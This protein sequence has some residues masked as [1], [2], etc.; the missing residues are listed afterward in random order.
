MFLNKHRLLAYHLLSYFHPQ[1]YVLFSSGR[2]KEQNIEQK[3]YYKS[4][5]FRFKACIR[6]SDVG[7]YLP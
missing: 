6:K 7:I 1:S 3:V 2:Y 5:F 4:T